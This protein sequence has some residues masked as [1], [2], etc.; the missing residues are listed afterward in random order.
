MVLTTEFQKVLEASTK[1]TSNCTG[2]LRLYIKYGGRDVANNK[3]IIYYEIRQYAH[4]PY[5]NYLGW[6]WYGSL[7][8]NIKLGTTIKANGTYTQSAVY[9]N[10]QEV[11]RASGSWEQPH[12]EDG[13]WSSAISFEGYVYQTKVSNNGSIELPQIPRYATSNQSLSSKTETSIVMNW[14]SDSIIDYLWYSINN[15]SS[16]IGIDVSDGTSGSYTI[17]GLSANTTYNIKTRVRRKDSQLTTDSSSLSV[18]TYAYPYIVSVSNTNLTIGDKVIIEVYNPLGRHCIA[19]MKQNSTSGKLLGSIEGFVAGSGGYILP[20]DTT[21][22]YES[23]PNS[24]SGNCVYYLECSSLSYTPSTVSGTYKIKGTEIPTVGSLSYK[25]SNSNTTAITENNQII[26][27]NNSNLVFT[28]GSASGNNGASISKYEVIFAGVTKS[29]TSAGDLDFGTINLASNNNATLKV[30]DSRGLTNTKQIT[31]IIDD[32]ILPTAITILKRK[33][34]FYSESYITVDASY[35]YLN[36]K[37]S[38]TIQC[39]YKKVTDS[40]YSQLQTLEENVQETLDLDNQYQWN[41]RVIVKDRLGTTTYNLVLDRGMPIIFYD[42]LKSS[43]GINCFPSG[44]ND[45]YVNGE[46]VR[47]GDLD[48]ASMYTSGTQKFGANSEQ[49]TAFTGTN[50]DIK[51]RDL[52]INTTYCRIDIPLGTEYIEIGGQVSGYNSAWCLLVVN[53]QYGNWVGESS[54]L[55]QPGGNG[56]WTGAF[57]VKIIKLDKTKSH[58]MYMRINAYNVTEFTLNAGFSTQNTNMWVRK[59]K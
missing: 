57:P 5:G 10:G 36:G 43:V 11:V 38:I 19:Y 37:N 3:D 8:W 14:A 24:S 47:T 4:N 6:E 42:R 49:V 32:W 59:L 21:A 35:S 27:R 40:D 56:Y 34:N 28:I 48:F 2:Y 17:G 26:I 58:Y 46:K 33:S 30:T 23:I 15:G 9:S 52:D 44:S 1:V 16:W 22:M 55:N 20:T 25:D 7:A 45:L 13:N 12:N 39:Q 31:V 54:L 41:I 51:T 53:D 50:S 18:A 29:R